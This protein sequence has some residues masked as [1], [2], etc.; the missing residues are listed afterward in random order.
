MSEAKILDEL[1]LDSHYIDV[2]DSSM[3]YFDEGQGEPILFLHGMPTWSYLWR[4]VIPYLRQ[5]YRCIAVDLIGMGRSGK[6]DIAYTAFDH[7][8]YINAFIEALDL[9]NI[10]LVMHAWGSVMGFH[11][12]MQHAN[13]IKAL[14]FFES[15]VR[16]NVDLDMVSLPMQEITSLLSQPD[17]G[18][19][20]INNSDF[21]VKSLLPAG[22]LRRLSDKEMSYYLEPFKS[23]GSRKPLWQYLQDLPLG[24][25]PK[26]IVALIDDYSKKLCDSEIPKLMLY[27]VPGFNTTIDTV[28][29]AQQHLPNLTQVD[30]GDA[31]HYIPESNPEIVGKTL[32][33]WFKKQ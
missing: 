25:G 32:S 33:E 18:Y 12:A 3:H 30:V 27:A 29:W 4:N 11:Y 31:L 22:I 7:I 2:L 15:H 1:L 24:E 21:F 13:N 6:P 17:G 28:R 14:A 5:D 23:P 20:V 16:A 26:D 19:E 9:K 10:R 8:R